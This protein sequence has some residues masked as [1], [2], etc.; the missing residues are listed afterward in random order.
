MIT[1]TSHK[2]QS[3]S[4]P[5]DDQM[6]KDSVVHD[7]PSVQAT[8]FVDADGASSPSAVTRRTHVGDVSAADRIQQQSEQFLQEMIQKKQE[9]KEW[10]GKKIILAQ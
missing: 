4:M 10:S 8:V 1:T 7:L 9:C 5:K 3:V 2:E 6:I